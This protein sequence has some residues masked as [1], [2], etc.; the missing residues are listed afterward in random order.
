M[1]RSGSSTAALWGISA[2]R[3]HTSQTASSTSSTT[4]QMPMATFQEPSRLDRGSIRAMLMTVPIKGN[5]PLRVFMV[6]LALPVYQ[7][8]MAEPMNGM[9]RPKPMEY[10]LRAARNM[11]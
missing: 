3:M 6:S 9:A 1:P 5:M 11:R 4:P 10:M 7:F 8:I 2:A